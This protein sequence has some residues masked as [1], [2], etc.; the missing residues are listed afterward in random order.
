MTG[1]GR[2]AALHSWP[3]ARGQTDNLKTFYC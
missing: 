2:D 3:A 1:S